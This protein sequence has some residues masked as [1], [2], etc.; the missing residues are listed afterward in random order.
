MLVFYSS[1]RCNNGI[2]KILREPQMVCKIIYNDI[3]VYNWI[4]DN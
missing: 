2:R 1:P 4:F 3:D